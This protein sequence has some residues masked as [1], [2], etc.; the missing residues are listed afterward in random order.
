MDT[1][2]IVVGTSL[3]VVGAFA[4]LGGTL[5]AFTTPL[6]LVKMNALQLGGIV[7]ALVGVGTLVGIDPLGLKDA[8]AG[9]AF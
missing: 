4:A 1:K 8:A 5:T 7:V 3:L 2:V 9:T 6:P